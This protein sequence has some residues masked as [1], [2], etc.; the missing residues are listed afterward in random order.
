MGFGRAQCREIEP[1]P[2]S[3]AFVQDRQEGA[4]TDAA[5]VHEGAA[6]VV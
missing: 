1:M 2:A 3:E 5:A 6:P 4:G